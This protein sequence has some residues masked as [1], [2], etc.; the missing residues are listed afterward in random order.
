MTD[1]N[2]TSSNA[3]SIVLLLSSILFS[4]LLGGPSHAVSSPVTN[5]EGVYQFLVT[6]ENVI[7]HDTAFIYVSNGLEEKI[8]ISIQTT[9]CYKCK[10][11]FL[12]SVNVRELVEVQADTSW[13]ITM[14]IS[15]K[16]EPPNNA[17]VCSLTHHF[18]QNGN[19]TWYI[20]S[21][22]STDTFDCKLVTMNN[23]PDAFI[24]IYVTLGIFA[25][26][27]LFCILVKQLLKST[28]THRFLNYFGME[29]VVSSD[30]GT[31]ANPVSEADS[32]SIQRPSRDKPKRLKSLDA[33]RGFSLIIMIFVNIGGGKYPF[34]G[35]SIWNGLTVADLVFP[36]FIWIMGVSITMSFYALLRHGVSRREM[37]YKIVRRSIILFGLGIIIDGGIDFSTFRVP[38]VLQ[39][40]AISYLVVATV[41]LFSVKHK[42]EEYRITRAVYRELR[43]LLDY[44]HEW[45]IM[46]S[47]LAL[48]VCLT[49]LLP[50]PGC[51]TGYLG[52]GGPLVGENGSLENCTGGAANYI[53]KVI[54]TYNHIYP[55][56]TP[57]RI[58]K[59]TV[60]H[61]PEGILGTLTSIFM[62]FLG[63][64]AGKIFHLFSFAR[65]RIIRFLIWC[66][67]TGVIA[68]G[69][70]GFSKEEGI[71][72]VNKNLW[73]VSFILT[74]ASMAF[75][76]LA[77]FYYL[78]DVHHLWTGVPFYFVGMNSIA[79]YCGSEVLGDYF[80]FCWK[81]V[82]NTHAELLAMNVIGTGLW[83]VISYYMYTINFF[84]KV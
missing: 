16:D 70:C 63:L 79:V 20:N 19:Y 61:D 8:S 51:P 53:D 65:D 76:L 13:P 80:P 10:L 21:K 83:V 12:G 5:E 84:V 59:T 58:Y 82:Y 30:L 15:L 22:K 33:F 24:P 42:V 31:P 2:M 77:I 23:P 41:H 54:L 49:F 43:D 48:H 67:L 47:F 71:I 57:R 52:P 18:K 75:F 32:N 56:G 4:T 64:Q 6:H 11:I 68:G 72:P 62:T 81:P 26:M 73:S 44:W 7:S 34:F 1:E 27:A 45:I 55:R 9:E 35:H 37:M 3:K 25:G 38:G 46:L 28:A 50:V 66:V 36:W 17:T 74:T 14:E 39:R 78:I 40:I 69:L 29:R 60:P